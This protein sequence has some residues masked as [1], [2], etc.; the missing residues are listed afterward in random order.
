L[1]A[2][3]VSLVDATKR[4]GGREALRGVTFRVGAGEA[5]GYLGPNGAGKTT[6]LRLLSGLSRVASGTVRVL[7]RDPIADHANALAGVGV[8]VETPGV[9]P[10]VT[11]AD[12]LGHI[13]EVK[14]VPVPERP[15]HLRA[16]AGS[17]G[18]AEHLH[19]PMGALSTGLAR[20][21]L[22]AGALIGDPE[23]LLLDEPTLG[24]DPAAREDLRRVLRSLKTSGR[25]ILLST[26]LLEDVEEVCDRV[27][28][29]R[30]GR[31]VGDEAVQLTTVDAQGLALRALRMR[32]SEDV[33]PARV[34]ALEAAVDRLE[35]PGPREV[36]LYFSGDERRAT[37]LIAIA[38]RS[39]LP[40]TSASE[41]TAELGRRYLERVGREDPK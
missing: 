8:L 34:V 12:L 36:L 16:I 19:R 22:L 5:V 9:L 35:R 15:A 40:L 4:Y 7:G 26:H 29:L 17:M 23:L 28:F 32:F 41:P 31:L 33:E 18:V 11:G 14:R 24:L 25:T 2:D 3:V 1:V 38:V 13:A 6:T 37:E 39:G 10:Y 21:V 30:D 27:L 20:R